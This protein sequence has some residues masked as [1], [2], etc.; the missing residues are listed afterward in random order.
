VIRTTLFSCAALCALTCLPGLA[1]RRAVE[2]GARS[3]TRIS[4]G[5][6]GLGKHA[7][8]VGGDGTVRCW[9]SNQYGQLGDGT[10][11]DRPS[12][13]RVTNL[14]NVISVA[15][16]GT[17]TCALRANGIV[18]C[19]GNN[20][21]GE[22]G[23]GTTTSRTT[24]ADV[25]GLTGVVA[26]AA[27][28]IHTCAAL[29]NGNVYCWGS[30]DSGQI[31]NGSTSL[32]VSTPALVAGG[33]K[34]VVAL[35]AGLVHTCALKSDG[36][37]FCWG[38]NTSGQ[39]GQGPTG[40]FT[41]APSFA[42]SGLS[43]A[44]SIAGGHVHTCAVRADGSALC[45]GENGNG[46]LGRGNTT[47]PLSSAAAPVLSL[48]GAIGITAGTSHSC[49][50]RSDG[51]AFCWGSNASGQ[52]GDGTTAQRLVPT[53]VL[54]LNTATE[55]TAGSNFTCATEPN[56]TPRCWGANSVGQLGDGTQAGETIPSVVSGGSGS[57]NARGIAAGYFETCARRDNGAG[58]CWGRGP[59]GD[60]SSSF[61]LSPITLTE[62]TTASM[63]VASEH[64]CFERSN[65]S[66]QCLGR[67]D[68]GQ[69]GDGSSAPLPTRAVVAS[70]LPN[71]V[72][73]AAG[74]LHTCAV[75]ANGT[76]TCWG[77][78][79]SGQVGD[80]TFV[81]RTTP[82]PV[83]GLTNIRSVIA[84]GAAH[85]CAVRGDG[86]VACWGENLDGELGDGTNTN[87]PTPVTV[88][89]LSRV[90][91]VAA[92]AGFTCAL[93]SD[94]VVLC[95]GRNGNGQLG[96]GTI[97]PRNTPVPVG[98]L[99]NATAITAGRDQTCAILADSTARCW[100]LNAS[101]QLGDST[102]TNRLTPTAVVTPGT[103]TFSGRTVSVL[104]SVADV[105]AVS[106]GFQ[107]TCLLLSNGQPMCW[108]DNQVGAV[109]DGT[110]T[111]RL[112]PVV[113]NS[114]TA[115]VEPQVS[116]VSQRRVADVTALVD[117]AAGQKARIL[118]TLEQGQ[119]T[120]Y[121]TAEMQCTG[122]LE[123]LPMTVEARGPNGFQ[124]GAATAVVEA[125][126]S[127]KNSV[128]QD[129]HWTRNVVLADAPAPGH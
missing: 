32:I 119:T 62:V 79:A 90:V 69:V 40:G 92:G 30:S 72:S 38:D 28:Q 29:Y 108:G 128:V 109:G 51:N 49:A 121:G 23:D 94:G 98:S 26:I 80:N 35:A 110:A 85:N 48:T 97:S 112:T 68:F 18:S 66:T 113:V 22:L 81:N 73:I 67:N 17:H 95:W 111:Q 36:T 74:D 76:A 19:W 25:P 91:S 54:G 16:A 100:G 7:C 50:V 117:C 10:T 11:T 93:R 55:I 107:H 12:P 78:N 87:R 125:I 6:T 52:I 63:V 41:A 31:G 60:G 34:D 103:L 58:A 123:K 44:V 122:G 83:S 46:Q 56:D 89:G 1:A 104:L 27:G 15:A 13:V 124:P 99:T 8:A 21:N 64:F 129:Q 2:V 45:W 71:A 39:L 75:L 105:V 106:A 5:A 59:N 9:G 118:L 61:R 47:K 20:L 96:D 14:S 120:G 88:L 43:N 82:T 114:F 57:I 126:I 127:D 65:G 24:T 3:G 70:L 86:T 102:T 37:V 53:Q 101:G 116:L 4:A 84:A 115:N 42:V 77:F 33:L